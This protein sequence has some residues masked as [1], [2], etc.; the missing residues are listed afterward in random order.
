M[1]NRLLKRAF[2]WVGRDTGEDFLQEE[3]YCS[4][5]DMFQARL[6]SLSLRLGQSGFKEYTLFIA[7]I[8][9]IGNNAF[10]H[11]LGKWRDV[12]GIYFDLDLI[13]KAVII[14]DRGQGVRTTLTQ[15]D[16]TL[17]SD[18]AALEMAFTRRISGRSPEQ[19]GNGLKFVKSVT[20]KQKWNLDFF[21][22]IG[23]A[24][25]EKGNAIQF[26]EFERDVK[27]TIAFIHI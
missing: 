26:G 7:V 11:N 21:S 8:G 9:E 25:I 23:K 18:L 22:G 6:Q 17:M 4:T 19:R 12:S 27:G 10:D 24:S 16:P 1:E 20:E 5:R 13:E 2:E 15:V 14:A 3:E